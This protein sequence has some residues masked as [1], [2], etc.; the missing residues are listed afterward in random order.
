MPTPLK[1]TY[2]MHWHAGHSSPNMRQMAT[3]GA[4]LQTPFS[5]LHQALSQDLPAPQGAHM[6]SGNH[7]SGSGQLE[8]KAGSI[9]RLKSH[10]G[11]RFEQSLEN[12]G[13]FFFG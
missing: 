5:F 11:G 6:N 7:S 9:Q 13:R 8:H 3:A 2:C 4:Q 10:R 12:E 1:H